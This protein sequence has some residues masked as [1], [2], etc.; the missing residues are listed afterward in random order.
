MKSN[1]CS[2]EINRR[3]DL[4]SQRIGMLKTLWSLD[5]T[6]LIIIDLKKQEK[7]ET[8]RAHLQDE[9]QTTCED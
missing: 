4:A 5:I 9:R 3:I 1:D 2:A 8:I 7:A 6:Q